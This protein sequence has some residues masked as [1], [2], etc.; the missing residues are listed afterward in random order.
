MS[1]AD[2]ASLYAIV[3]IWLFMAIYAFLSIGGFRYILRSSVSS[4]SNPPPGGQY[5]MVSILVPAHN[6]ALVLGRTVRSLLNFDYPKNRYE[7]II[8]NDNSDDNTLE[9]LQAIQREYSDRRLIVIS[10]DRTVGGAGKS[11][12]LNIGLSV[13]KGSLIAVYDADNTPEPSAL[14]ILT[15]NLISDPKIGATVGKF[16]TRN[17][18]A[19]LLTRFV[20][21]E[22]LAHQCMNQAGRSFFFRLCTI[23]G[24]NYL[25]R[26][27]IIEKIGGWDV[28][29]LSEDTEISFRIYRM[30][31]YIK[32]L[33]QAV[34]WEQEPYLLSVW[35]RQRTRW[36]RGNIY[37][38]V[39][40]F[41]YTFDPKAGP[42]RLDTLYFAMVYVL[43]LSSLITSD[44][45]FVGGLMGFIHVKLAG[46][47]SLLWGMAIVVFIADMML[48]L[49][50]ERNEFSLQ[51][52]ALVTL[53]LFT[54]AKLW[55]FVM[56]RAVYLSIM[57]HLFHREVKWDKTVR[58][59]ESTN[60]ENS[61]FKSDT[62]PM[63]R[64]Q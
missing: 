43:M 13:A 64:K 33:P 19:S 35:F 6:E 46:F 55:V 12:A 24:T 10:T 59:V 45:I 25:I 7:I 63:G 41:K 3:T 48:T 9:I 20:N 40:N 38:L 54:Y 62:M 1:V 26:R 28:K 53:M 47:S 18:N 44:V 32:F 36:A 56:I 51:S 27:D 29:A 21:I 60:S 34:T 57:D 30:G 42:M 14:R 37:V 2:A 61:K 50:L 58:Y 11:N 15:E 4:G 23:P 22:T 52:A 31:Y 16:R 8:I 49:S 5:P 17:R 39:K